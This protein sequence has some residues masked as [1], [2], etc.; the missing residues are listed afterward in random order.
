MRCRISIILTIMLA[1]FATSGCLISCALAWDDVSK[2]HSCCPE[3]KSAATHKGDCHPGLCFQLPVKLALFEAT[4][5]LQIVGS[6]PER[7]LW[8]FAPLY[9]VF[10]TQR[11]GLARYRAL[12][13]PPITD[14][15]YSLHLSPN[16]PPFLRG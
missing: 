6:V 4:A 15:I 3:G 8:V 14:L 1:F 5:E 10:G 16:A 11:V 7:A 9:K 2:Q 12:S 13:P